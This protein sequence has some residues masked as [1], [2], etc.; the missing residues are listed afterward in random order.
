M[1]SVDL[2][3]LL[4]ILLFASALAY[5]STFLHG[6]KFGHFSLLQILNLVIFPG[7]F[8]VVFYSH[9][10]SIIARPLADD[11]FIPDALLVL[12]VLL[13]FVFT[14]GGIAVHAVTKMLSETALRSDDSEVG[15][16][17]KY[18]H[19]R[20]SHN[21][22]ISG[23]VSVLSG[24]TLLELN[25]SPADG[26]DRLLPPVFKGMVIGLLFSIAMYW[27]TRSKDQYVGKWSDLKASFLMLWV[28][29]IFLLYSVR[30]VDP[31]VSDYQL[32]IPAILGFSIVAL[33][34]VALVFRRLKNGKIRISFLW[35]RLIK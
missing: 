15:K 5:K 1:L 22:F 3:S 30:Q 17:N 25:H 8:F 28:G 23:G 6:K 24:L 9:M 35:K 18:F 16:L 21:M 13:S 20:F 7:F 11:I 2:F 29:L 14:Y 12:A 33:L 31:R 19:L 34:N 26:Y 10:Q 32:L 27:Y 4:L